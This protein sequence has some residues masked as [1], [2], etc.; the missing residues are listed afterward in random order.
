MNNVDTRISALRIIRAQCVKP[1]GCTSDNGLSSSYMRTV[2][3][4]K[5]GNRW[6]LSDRATGATFFVGG[7][8]VDLYDVTLDAIRDQGAQH[9]NEDELCRLALSAWNAC[10]AVYFVNGVAQTEEDYKTPSGQQRIENARAACGSYLRASGFD[11][12]EWSA[13]P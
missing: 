1:S 5:S 4:E 8:G 6:A 7:A 9:D 3:C 11:Y 13:L 12:E 10:V 2:A